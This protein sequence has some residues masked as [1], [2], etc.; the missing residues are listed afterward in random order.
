MENNFEKLAELLENAKEQCLN[1]ISNGSEETF[2]ESLET[3]S[4]IIS[5]VEDTILKTIENWNQRI[6]CSFSIISPSSLK[7]T[8]YM[9]FEYYDDYPESDSV[10]IYSDMVWRIK[11]IIEDEEDI[12]VIA[13]DE[14]YYLTKECINW[15]FEKA[16]KAIKNANDMIIH[17]LE[18]DDMINS[19]RISIDAIVDG[20]E[21]ITNR[22][23]ELYQDVKSDFYILEGRLFPDDP[24]IWASFYI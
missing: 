7:D 10:D 24:K 9:G 4:T 15:V 19:I 1:E 6:N 16:Q 11:D 21:E 12:K 13:F 17:I 23:K 3:L 5:N 2:M 18:L 14:N 20:L 22:E 8:A